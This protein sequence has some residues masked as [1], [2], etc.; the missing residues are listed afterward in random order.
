MQCDQYPA[1]GGIA[2]LDLRADL[3][4]ALLYDLDDI[5]D[6]IERAS[7]RETAARVACGAVAKALL[8]ELGCVVASHVVAIGGVTADSGMDLED[9]AAVE[10]SPVRCR[11][12]V[13]ARRMVAAIDAAAAAGD[14]VGGVVEVIAF[15]YPPGAGS[16]VQ[17]SPVMLPA[18]S[19]TT[20]W[21]VM[22]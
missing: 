21:H 11:D 18:L 7:A 2:H 17:G 16:Y 19:F 10:A 13:A 1:T 6:V 14:T 4:G 22:K 15:G 5:R 20:S 3:G 9:V 8:A 12:E